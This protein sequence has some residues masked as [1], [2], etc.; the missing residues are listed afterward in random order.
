[1]G[2]VVM[3][4]G[5][6]KGY[7]R[8]SAKRRVLDGADLDGSRGE[9]V[10]VV[11]P[12]GSGKSTLLHLLAGLDRPDAGA[13]EV[14]GAPVHRLDERSLT[15]LRREQIGLIFQAFHLV[16]ELSGAE[17][18]VLPARANG[19]GAAGMARARSLI[20]RLGLVEAAARRPAE[21]SGG[22]QQRLAIAR[23]L[24][25]DPALVLADEPTGNL[26]DASGAGVLGLL[27]EVADGGRAVLVV[28][29]DP[30]A[31]AVA[32]RT[33]TMADGRLAAA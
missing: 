5:L 33:L 31:G 23:A 6:V 32:D 21:L 28:T 14:A 3:A 24:V 12:S 8:G 25:N 17:N 29:H 1:M 15:R 20:E 18:V 19:G 30:R 10:A 2:A 16:P 27:R 26:D 13:I 22:E 9:L 4:R 11:G 7:G